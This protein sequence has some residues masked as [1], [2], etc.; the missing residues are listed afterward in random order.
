[1]DAGS[2]TWLIC[3][4]EDIWHSTEESKYIC[5]EVREL[6]EPL[7]TRKKNTRLKRGTVM[8]ERQVDSLRAILSYK[9]LQQYKE[10]GF[11]NLIQAV[12]LSDPFSGIAAGKDIKELI[13]HIPTILFWDKMKRYLFGTFSDFEEQVRLA[14]K[15]SHDNRKYNEFIKKLIH[16][17]NEIDDDKKVDYFALLTRCFLL[18]D[19]NQNLFFKLSKYIMNCTPEELQFLSEISFDYQSK[20]TAFVSS[21]YQYG[22]FVQDEKQ[23][24]VVYILSDFGKALKQNSLNFDSELNGKSRIVSYEEVTPLPITEPATADDIERMFKDMN[25]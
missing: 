19:L 24:G 7:R 10:D 4:T 23:D 15:L 6:S 2:K 17:I 13:F 1:M 3:K 22:L 8:L 21:L 16:L 9:D 18:T 5:C 20:N 11:W 25:G 12:V 14:V